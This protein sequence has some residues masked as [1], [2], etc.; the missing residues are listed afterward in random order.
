MVESRQIFSFSG[1][2][3]DLNTGGAV[4]AFVGYFFPKKSASF[5]HFHREKTLVLK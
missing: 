2:D 3:I 4:I 5:G 1:T